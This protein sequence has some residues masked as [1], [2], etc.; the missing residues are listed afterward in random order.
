MIS[1]HL[2]AIPQEAKWCSRS[3]QQTLEKWNA[4]D[5]EASKCSNDWKIDN[6][7]PHR[8]H[9]HPQHDVNS[10]KSSPDDCQTFDHAPLYSAGGSN[11]GM[12]QNQR[13]RLTMTYRSPPV[14]MGHFCTTLQRLSTVQRDSACEVSVA[15]CS[16]PADWDDADR[17]AMLKACRHANANDEVRYLSLLL[18]AL[19]TICCHACLAMLRQ[20]QIHALPH[21]RPA[22]DT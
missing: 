9:H 5:H 15:L 22:Q 21:C 17:P 20:L 4:S 18:Y 11:A 13:M 19:Q 14:T 8:S 12:V 2:E 6:L 16:F 1:A 3:K 7:Q 10:M